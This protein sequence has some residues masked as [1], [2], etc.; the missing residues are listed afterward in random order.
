MA[1]AELGVLPFV[2]GIDLSRND[3]QV[4]YCYFLQLRLIFNLYFIISIHH[5]GEIFL[6]AT[7]N[8]QL[9]KASF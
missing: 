8:W 2:R 1:A 7:K 9:F 5:A 4:I 6:F 3:F